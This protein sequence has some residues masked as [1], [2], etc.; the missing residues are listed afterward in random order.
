MALDAF[1][2]QISVGSGYEGGG[3]FGVFGAS[4]AMVLLISLEQIELEGC[5]WAQ[6]KAPEE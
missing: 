1:V 3:L 2:K 4:S 5:V 6:I